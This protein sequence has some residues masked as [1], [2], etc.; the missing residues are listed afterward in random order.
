MIWKLNKPKKDDDES[1][2][3]TLIRKN[4]EVHKKKNSVKKKFDSIEGAQPPPRHPRQDVSGD[5][6]DVYLD[7]L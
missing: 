1:T 3:N 7:H 5:D 6:L 2:S 4:N